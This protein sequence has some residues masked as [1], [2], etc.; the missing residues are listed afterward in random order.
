MKQFCI[1]LHC[2]PSR[3]TWKSGE[4]EE[5]Y[6]PRT[7]PCQGQG[8]GQCILTSFECLCGCVRACVW[9]CVHVCARA[10][11]ACVYAHTRVHVC[12]VWA[13]V[14]VCMH[15][16]VYI[17]TCMRAWV[18]VHACVCTGPSYLRLTMFSFLVLCL[19]YRLRVPIQK[20]HPIKEDVTIF[21]STLTVLQALSLSERILMASI[22]RSPAMTALVVAMAG[23]MLPAM[24]SDT[25]VL[26]TIKSIYK[27][28]SMCN[29]VGFCL[30]STFRGKKWD[31]PGIT[32][33]CCIY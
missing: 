12:G 6:L 18:C 29:V 11:V 19:V 8:K 2:K 30:L 4:Q 32:N 24:A 3:Y 7:N 9:L 16:C 13:C 5:I 26:T 31:T 22:M 23:M 17:Y 14:Y 33:L 10:C 25:Q 20:N 27:S 15:V 28:R 1:E 21:P